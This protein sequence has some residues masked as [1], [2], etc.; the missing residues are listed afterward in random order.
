MERPNDERG[1]SF[2]SVRWSR[3]VLFISYDVMALPAPARAIDEASEK[4]LHPSLTSQAVQS[5][6]GEGAGFTVISS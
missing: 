6:V 4:A 1:A 2:L 3:T 5:R